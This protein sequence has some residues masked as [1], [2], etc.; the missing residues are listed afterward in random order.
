MKH[1]A[2][3]REGRAPKRAGGLKRAVLERL[4]LGGAAG[5]VLAF[6]F[7][8][9]TGLGLRL[10]A[11]PAPRLDPVTPAVDPGDSE[12]PRVEV[13]NASTRAGLARDAT[14]RLR[15]AGFDVVFYGNAPA[16]VP[17]STVVLDRLGRI[18]AAWGVARALGIE[19]VRTAIDS[20]LLL[21]VSV[22]LGSD[23]SRPR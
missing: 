1:T 22:I 21:E 17:D 8:F 16:N 15:D 13:L 6:V 3:A 14:A 19:R 2:K 9:A 11:G 18:E 4:A 7:S 5:L 12:R 23:W 20:T 10:P